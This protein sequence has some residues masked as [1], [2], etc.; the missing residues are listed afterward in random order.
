MANPVNWFEIYV[1]DMERAKTFYQAVCG[2]ELMNLPSPD[3]GEMWVFPMEEGGAGAA[4]SLVKHPQ[5]KPGMGGT[6]VLYL[7]RG[8]CYRSRTRLLKT[9]GTLMQEKMS[10]GEYGYIAIF[11]DTEGNAVGLHSHA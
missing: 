9:V 5:G 8:L 4:G 10:I 6:M 3:E 2:V 1:D 7:L 11:E